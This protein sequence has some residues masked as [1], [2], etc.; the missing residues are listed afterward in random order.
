MMSR[1]LFKLGLYD[2]ELGE[3]EKTKQYLRMC[4]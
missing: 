3:I 2:V 4:L 1:I